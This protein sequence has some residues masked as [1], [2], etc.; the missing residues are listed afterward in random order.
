LVHA[1]KEAQRTR[2]S[3]HPK[4]EDVQIVIEKLYIENYE[5]FYKLPKTHIS[6]L[7]ENPN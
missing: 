7:L 3:T 2:I 1:N 4:E 5:D 6:E